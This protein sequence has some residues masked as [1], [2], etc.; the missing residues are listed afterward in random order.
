MCVDKL[1]H[2][3]GK[4]LSGKRQRD[5]ETKRQRDRETE[6]KRNKET[7]RRDTKIQRDEIQKDRADNKNP[8]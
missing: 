7:E 2:T 8:N 1:G 4:F 3:A 5:K 6:Q